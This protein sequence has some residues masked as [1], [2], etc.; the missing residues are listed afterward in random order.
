MK[1]DK[2]K[3]RLFQELCQT[4]SKDLQKFIY[5]ITRQDNFAMEE[6]FQNTME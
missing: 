4:Y 1:I 3:H 2:L 5:T 6:V